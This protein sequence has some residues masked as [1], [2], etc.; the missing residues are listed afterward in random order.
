[1]SLRTIALGHRLEQHVPIKLIPIKH[2]LMREEPSNQR[3]TL[4]Q[5]SPPLSIRLA[6]LR[7][8]FRAL[9]KDVVHTEL[10]LELDVGAVEEVVSRCLAGVRVV[11]EFDLRA[12]VGECKGVVLEVEYMS[13]TCQRG[14]RGR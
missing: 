10:G 12:E 7:I 11:D 3:N 6:L 9:R 13:V 2:R 14:R 1:M 5:P 4:R 8:M